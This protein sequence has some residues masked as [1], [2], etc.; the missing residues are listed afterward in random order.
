MAEF[1]SARTL[2]AL[3]D[4]DSDDEFHITPTMQKLWTQH[5]N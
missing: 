3:L 4:E 2:L 1:P 5:F